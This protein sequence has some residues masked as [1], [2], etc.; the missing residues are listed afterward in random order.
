MAES[1]FAKVPLQPLAKLPVVDSTEVDGF[2]QAS[3]QLEEAAQKNF[4][5]RTENEAIRQGIVDGQQ[6]KF[7]TELLYAP[8]FR[9]QAYTRA[10]QK[11]F[12]DTVELNA[13]QKIQA[14][15]ASN[16]NDHA[17]AR[18][19]INGYLNG[20]VSGFPP[21]IRQRLGQTFL[22]KSQ[23]RANVGL[24]GI[25]NRERRQ[26]TNL[27]E[28]QAL[29]RDNQRSIDIVANAENIFDPDAKISLKSIAA[30]IE[31]RSQIE[32]DYGAKI[33]D[34]EG[35]QI[36]AFNPA[37]RERALQ[38]FD[39]DN[40]NAAIKSF[41]NRSNNKEEFLRQFEAN[42]IDL[43][44]PDENGK[45]VLDLRPNVRRKAALVNYMRGE[46]SRENVQRNAE[47][48]IFRGEAKSD[49]NTLKKGGQITEERISLM[50]TRAHQLQDDATFNVL[51]DWVS[52]S[53]DMHLMS[54]MTPSNLD[55]FVSAERSAL[56]NKRDAGELITQTD[57]EQLEAKEALLDNMSTELEKDPLEWANTVGLI[58]K[59]PIIPTAQETIEVN[60]QQIR[61][62]ELMNKRIAQAEAVGIHYGRPPRFLTDEEKTTFQKF[63]TDRNTGPDAKLSLLASLSGFG[64]R[65]DEV[66]AEISPKAPEYMHIAGMM[67]QGSQPSVLSDAMEGLAIIQGAGTIQGTRVIQTHTADVVAVTDNILGAAYRESPQ[68]RKQV[69]NVAEAI[70]T[71]RKLRQGKTDSSDFTDILGSSDGE[72]ATALQEAAGANFNDEGKQFGGVTEYH[73]DK[74]HIPSWMEADFFEKFIDNLT[75][76]D[77]QDGGFG[78][79][80]IIPR[81][82]GEAD[83]VSIVKEIIVHGD[84]IK[85]ISIGNGQYLV[86]NTSTGKDLIYQSQV[87]P[88]SPVAATRNGWY[89]L[90]LNEIP[91]SRRIRA[92][93]KAKSF[94]VTPEEIDEFQ[95]R[96]KL[97]KSDIKSEL[98][99]GPRSF[100]EDVET[101]KEAVKGQIKKTKQLVRDLTSDETKQ[102]IVEAIPGLLD[103]GKKNFENAL[104]IIKEV[105]S[106]IGDD[107]PQEVKSLII[108]TEQKAKELQRNRAAFNKLSKKKRTAKREEELNNR[109][110]ALS[111]Q[112]ERIKQ[113]LRKG[114]E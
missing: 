23:I 6:G 80:P 102:L 20:V 62:Q 22:L 78:G 99:P 12:L 3:T 111:A 34:A 71:A 39:I 81:A 2:F 5:T 11:S 31:Q 16:P 1:R 96:Q 82:T 33:T 41:F 87:D 94:L 8:T 57:V 45:A 61:P 66:L 95:E 75:D 76:K 85:L 46:I 92:L 108:D 105:F 73:D 7:N 100:S 37:F 9:G 69:V 29:A 89:V 51:A 38:Q 26:Q 91:S 63:L 18:Q 14:I 36:G 93:N 83:P 109:A 21:A 112:T 60:G 28:V 17:A 84:D 70:Y 19:Q 53:N 13:T 47:L 107:L 97:R 56:E 68:T 44:V 10:A 35:V 104:N 27:A 54:V 114:K 64:E 30:V 43:I 42:E 24:S 48:R 90:D 49:V 79:A 77:W 103:T 58:E 15:I 52:H 74:V 88:F 40:S 55:A 98:V 101:V 65:Q 25:L 110:I 4:N 59:T 86:S 113:M 32:S 67:K 50:K 106:G 72:W